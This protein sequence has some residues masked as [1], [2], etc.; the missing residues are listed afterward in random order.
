MEIQKLISHYPSHGG[1]ALSRP[2]GKNVVK[3]TVAG[4]NMAAM[5]AGIRLLALLQ[6]ELRNTSASI[7]F[8]TFPGLMKWRNLV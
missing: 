1:G 3:N 7:S 4:T 5:I 2:N 6:R 8:P